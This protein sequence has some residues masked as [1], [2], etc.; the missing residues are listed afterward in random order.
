MDSI[1]STTGW[2]A[3]FSSA[4][5]DHSVADC[6]CLNLT[7]PGH[8]RGVVGNGIFSSHSQFMSLGFTP[9]H[10]LVLLD[11]LLHL[12]SQWSTR[13]TL[14]AVTTISRFHFPL[15]LFTVAPWQC[16]QV[17]TGSCPTVQ[18]IDK[19]CASC[20]LFNYTTSETDYYFCLRHS[21][22]MLCRLLS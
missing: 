14:F 9:I 19:H 5:I 17:T 8:W 16:T 11:L 22:G 10:A 7:S 12:Q 21:T 18:W 2:F 6:A 1:L 15:P 3:L 20:T 4:K 13:F